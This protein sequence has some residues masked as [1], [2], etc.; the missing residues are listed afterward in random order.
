MAQHAWWTVSGA[1]LQT[2]LVLLLDS[3]ET[4]LLIMVA[5]YTTAKRQNLSFF[6]SEDDRAAGT[7]LQPISLAADGT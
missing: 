1:S 6:C 4:V 3:L 5:R 2:L 7:A